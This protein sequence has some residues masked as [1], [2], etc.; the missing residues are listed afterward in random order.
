MLDIKFIRENS[1]KVK[2]QLSLRG[3]DVKELKKLLKLDTAHRKIIQELE[4]IKSEKNK[5][6]RSISKLDKAKR[7][8]ELKK[9]KTLD[10][11]ADELEGRL[12]EALKLLS[13][14]LNALPNLPHAEVPQGKNEKDNTVIKTVGKKTTFDFNAKDYMELAEIHDLIDTERAA[15]V[16]GSRFGYLKKDG[17][18]LWNAL[19]Q[20]CLSVI[21]KNGFIPFYSPSL[22]KEEVMRNSGYDTYTDGHDAYYIEKD[23]LYLVGTGEH[24]LL[25]YHSNE[26]LDEKELPLRYTTY[27][28]CYRREAGSYGKDTK[29]ILRVHQFEKQEMLII[30]TPDKSWEA[31]DELLK[32]QEKIVTS[33]GIPYQLLEVCTGDLPK[34]S[35]RVI[36]L[37]C[38]I[39]SEKKY[40]ETHSASNCTDYQARRNKIRYKTKE[41]KNEMVHILNATVVTPR[42]LIALLENY[43][44]QDGSIAIPKVL[45]MYM[46]GKSMITST[47]DGK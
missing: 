6:S 17:A 10:I 45:Q 27:S 43:Q 7:E 14:L 37:E 24:A 32:I 28:S 22:V 47:K 31:F 15:K 9:M 35:A 34:P 44:Q 5:F 19:V 38:W 30:T 16:S 2:K 29:G 21:L 1:D 26:I 36:D 40:R 13:V 12:S 4:N 42:L 33:I 20:Y 46:D 11:Q 8:A 3:F 23:K 39:P 25:P 41:G 18:L